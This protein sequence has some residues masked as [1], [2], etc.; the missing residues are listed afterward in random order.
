MLVFANDVG[1]RNGAA[2]T[3]LDPTPDRMQA[4]RAEPAVEFGDVKFDIVEV[5]RERLFADEVIHRLNRALRLR[6]ERLV[7]DQQ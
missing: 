5:V 1:G 2:L 7:G 3:R 4:G 6:G